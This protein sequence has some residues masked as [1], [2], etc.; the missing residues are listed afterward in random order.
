[1]VLSSISTSDSSPIS[2]ISGTRLLRQNQR[3]T[4]WENEQNETKNRGSWVADSITETCDIIIWGPPPEFLTTHVSEQTQ[5][6]RHKRKWKIKLIAGWLDQVSR[7]LRFRHT[8]IRNDRWG[9][10]TRWLMRNTEMARF[11]EGLP[12]DYCPFTMTGRWWKIAKEQRIHTDHIR[13]L[14][15]QTS[16]NTELFWSQQG[17]G[18]LP[19]K[20]EERKR[21]PYRGLGGSEA[22]RV[23]SW[24]GGTPSSS[25]S[26]SSSTGGG[27]VGRGTEGGAGTGVRWWLRLL[28]GA[29]RSFS[30][31]A[32]TSSSSG[33]RGV[34][35]RGG[36]GWGASCCEVEGWGAGTA[37][38][39]RIWEI[40]GFVSGSK[41]GNRGAGTHWWVCPWAGDGL[42]SGAVAAS[43]AL[44]PV[45]CR[46]AWQGHGAVA[47][48]GCLRGDAGCHGDGCPG[49]DH[50]CG[51]DLW[52]AAAAGGE[53]DGDGSELL[54]AGQEAGREGWGCVCLRPPGSAGSYAW[55]WTP[56]GS[57]WW[58]W[59]PLR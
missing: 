38:D 24:A 32:S 44:A 18:N 40:H 10:K 36:G 23:P 52:A 14:R 55:A 58:S 47:G 51:A 29:A 28:P 3:N 6:R 4:K 54:L 35:C 41:R 25:E 33:R 39:K 19:R 9:I 16:L 15:Q 20:G 46:L 5:K 48:A 34:S 12:H 53:G 1:M 17:N 42:L 49:D 50:C 59:A 2:V 37:E 30:W 7:A 27:A 43:L 8:S 57:A 45:P 31:A 22:R 13:L 21:G 56:Q 26:S 11:W